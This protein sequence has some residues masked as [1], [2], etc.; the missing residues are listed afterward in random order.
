MSRSRSKSTQRIFRAN[1]KA[2]TPRFRVA[3][4]TALRV[5]DLVAAVT[6]GTMGT[7]IIAITGGQGT[8][9]WHADARGPWSC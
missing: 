2:G 4:A 7:K 3:I 8:R 5:G 6:T 1:G 9:R